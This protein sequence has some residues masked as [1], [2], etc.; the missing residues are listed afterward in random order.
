MINKLNRDDVK[1]AAIY[2]YQAASLI[3]SPRF[4]KHYESSSSI[5]KEDIDDEKQLFDK[6]R[7]D[8]MYQLVQSVSGDWRKEQR[9][10]FNGNCSLIPAVDAL[11]AMAI[12]LVE[13]GDLICDLYHIKCTNPDRKFILKKGVS[14]QEAMNEK[15]SVPHY[16]EVCSTFSVL[17]SPMAEIRGVQTF[18]ACNFLS[19]LG[20][21]IYATSTLTIG[22]DIPG[23]MSAIRSLMANGAG[24]FVK[25]Y[26]Y[27]LLVH[28]L[29]SYLSDSYPCR[30][31]K[32]NDQWCSV[33]ALGSN[34][35]VG[36][37]TGY[38]LF[39]LNAI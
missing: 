24:Y 15:L 13:L 20:K 25:G 39:N 5:F 14:L 3:S 4:L 36:S 32:A 9:A 16:F 23:Y 37:T 26:P 21:Y 8:L 34:Q 28:G 2:I 11:N 35:D 22:V 17:S 27:D 6:L 30:V 12:S 33:D 18:G 38:S 19:E 7:S 29:T 10:K 31:L 1:A